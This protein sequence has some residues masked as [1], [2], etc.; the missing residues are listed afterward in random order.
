MRN[1]K[2]KNMNNTNFTITEASV[3][4]HPKFGNLRVMIDGEGNPW[5]V[6]KVVAEVLGYNRGRDAIRN[7]IEPED[8]KLLI[9]KAC[10]DLTR[11]TLW[12]TK[13]YSNKTLI[14]ESGLYSLILASKLPQARVF[15]HWVTAEVLPSIRKDGAYVAATPEMS[16]EELMARALKAADSAIARL[17]QQLID[18]QPDVNFAHALNGSDGA[19]KMSEMAKILT[20]NGFETGLTR[21]Y[22][23][24]RKDGYI[25]KNS[26]EP[27][28]QWVEKGIFCLK[29]TLVS[30]HRGSRQ[31]IT[32][33]VTCKGQQYFIERYCG[34]Q[35]DKE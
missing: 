10:G 14:N 19:V 22:A 9:Y 16:D 11:A 32:P 6:G 5:F 4:N 20:Q 18:Q 34:R 12:T 8:S 25:F 27:I 24:L 31:T 3:F 21:F 35:E 30:T 26:T 29:A 33:L 7:H 17:K 23:L 13:D 1:S 15:K 28:Q 2:K